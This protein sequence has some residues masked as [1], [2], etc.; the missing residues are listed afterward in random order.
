MNL[1]L[2][3]NTASLEA[4]NA[5]TF[6]IGNLSKDLLSLPVIYIAS[7]PDPKRVYFTPIK[8]MYQ[9]LGFKQV[10]Y[11]ELEDG[12]QANASTLLEKAGLIHLSGG[13]TY[14]FLTGLK[15]RGIDKQLRCLAE[16]GTAIVGV[17]AGAMIMTPSI[18]S[19]ILCGDENT[20]GLTDTRGLHL[21]SFLMVPHVSEPI[22]NLSEIETFKLQS[23]NELLLCKD[24]DAVVI[25]GKKQQ[26]F[27]TPIWLK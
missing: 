21:V 6:F 16:E 3:S 2:L 14:R 1:V 10:D 11:I 5:L 19:A 24:T 7:Q 13:D 27:G 23:D 18:D 25:N 12:F 17:S 15:Q 20:V 22:S 8:I 9:Q 4:M 26:T